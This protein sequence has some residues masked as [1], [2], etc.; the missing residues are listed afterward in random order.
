MEEKF[1][2]SSSMQTVIYSIFSGTSINSGMLK[3]K[4]SEKEMIH[5][6]DDYEIVRKVMCSEI[7][8]ISS[9]NKVFHFLILSV[10]V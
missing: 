6:P 10:L 2:N 9:Q 8:L 4:L 3:T 5:L 1:S 7:I